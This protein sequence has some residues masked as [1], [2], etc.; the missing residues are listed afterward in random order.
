MEPKEDAHLRARLTAL[1]EINKQQE[2]D[3]EF[4]KSIGSNVAE[5]AVEDFLVDR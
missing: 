2:L 5:F 3:V 4:L 1:R